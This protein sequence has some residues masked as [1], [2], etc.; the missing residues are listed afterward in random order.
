MDLAFAK[1][2]GGG[3]TCADDIT[4]EFIAQRVKTGQIVHG[5]FTR[6]RNYKFHQRFFCLMQLGF[7]VWSDT[8]KAVEYRGEFIRPN[9]ERFR[10][11]ITIL[12]GYYETDVR[13][14][15]TI[16]VEAKSIS[17]GNMDQDEF[18]KLYSECINVIL[19]RI[20]GHTNLTP[21]QLRARVEQ[22]LE[23]DK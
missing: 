14:D 15:G 12:A 21:E 13:L 1:T 6:M 20:M 9:L 7:D 8:A 11:D 3:V 23:F 5:T 2:V 10:K 19:D 17:F 22:V 4:R 16:R 18:E